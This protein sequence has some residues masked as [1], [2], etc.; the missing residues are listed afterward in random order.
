M[1]SAIQA[2]AREPQVY[3]ELSLQTAQVWQSLQI[4]TKYHHLLERLSALWGV[5]TAAAAAVPPP[6]E[7]PPPPTTTIGHV[8]LGTV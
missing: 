4:Q 6:V 5:P 1:A 7:P 2:V 3:R 8:E